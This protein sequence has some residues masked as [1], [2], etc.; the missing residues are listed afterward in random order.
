MDTWVIVFLFVGV[1]VSCALAYDDGTPWCAPV[2]VKNGHVSCQTPRGE[3]YKNV[4]GTRCKIG[5]KKGYE[6]VGH[7]EIICMANKR[8]SGNYACRE[9]RC[10]KLTMPANGGYKCSDGS[11]FNSRCEFFCSPGYQLKGDRMVMCM[12]NKAWTGR[13]TSCV[14]VEPPTIKCPSVKEKTAEPGKLTARVHWDTP[15]GRDTADGTLTDVLLK[16][17]SPGSD[18]PEGD[19]RIQYTVYDRAGNKGTCR[20]SVKVRVRRCGRLSPPDN[21]YMKCDG[22]GDNYGATCEFSCM[23]GYELQGSTARVCQYGM[24][25]VGSEA[26]CSPMNINVGVRT[27]ASFLDQFYEKRRLIFLSAPT[28]AHHHYRTQME[29]LQ[30]AQCGIDLRHVSIVELVGVYPAQIGRIGHRL[31]HPGLALQLRLLL[32]ISHNS[33][34]MVLVDKHG[35]DKERYTFPVTAAELFTLIDSFP[36]RQE[37]MKLQQEAG[38]TCS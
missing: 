17:R 23:G 35:T 20:F 32:Q 33:Y 15:E 22:D 9:I 16:G 19:H 31:I 1:H 27:A 2:K 38:Q 5:C 28:A 11:Y 37:E 10:P 34:N 24:T 18:F 26:S 6:V 13:H 8:W 25:W 12:S 3:Y 4:M 29:I 14:D 7:P 21:G 36:L 30:Q